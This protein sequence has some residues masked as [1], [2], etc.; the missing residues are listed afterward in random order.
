MNFIEEIPTRGKKIY[1]NEERNSFSEFQSE[2]F[3][4]ES[5]RMI[6]EA[7][8]RLEGVYTSSV[9]MGNANIIA[10]VEDVDT[11]EFYTLSYAELEKFINV[12]NTDSRNGVITGI[13]KTIPTKRKLEFIE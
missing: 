2:N 3:P 5:Q 7:N 10:K 9:Y 12:L 13:F 8:I 11:G 1:I 6:V 4:I